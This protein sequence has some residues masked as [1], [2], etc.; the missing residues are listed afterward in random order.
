M[1]I[2]DSTTPPTSPLY[3]LHTLLKGPALPRVPY[4]LSPT[5]LYYTLHPKPYPTLPYPRGY[6]TY[7]NLPYSTPPYPRGYPTYSTTPYPTL[8]Y[9]HYF[10]YH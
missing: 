4:L 10:Y 1:C 7:S 8:P 3:T 6:P 2:R 9:L 5:L